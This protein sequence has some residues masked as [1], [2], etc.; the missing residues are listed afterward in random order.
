ML[1]RGIDEYYKTRCIDC[2]KLYKAARK[3][4]RPPFNETRQSSAP[5][6]TV[7]ELYGLLGG[8]IRLAHPDKHGNSKLSNEATAWLL[9][10]RREVKGNSCS[11]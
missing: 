4:N 10:K 6:P 5:D 11:Q 8:L 9:E 3:Q 1:S 2:W 7:T